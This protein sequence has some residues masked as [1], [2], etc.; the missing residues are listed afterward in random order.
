MYYTTR[1]LIAHILTSHR[2]IL[3]DE[4]HLVH[5]AQKAEVYK[6]GYKVARKGSLLT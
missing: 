6:D 1:D 5:L 3:G 2:I 4:V